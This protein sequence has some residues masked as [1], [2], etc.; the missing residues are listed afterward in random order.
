MFE[1]FQYCVTANNNDTF[2]P[3]FNGNISCV[4]GHNDDCILAET[5]N[6]REQNR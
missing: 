1:S 2:N 6:K 4:N 3:Y 5:F